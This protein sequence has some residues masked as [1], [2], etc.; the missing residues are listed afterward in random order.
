[1]TTYVKSIREDAERNA[2]QSF[3]EHI[4][5]PAG[6]DRWWFRRKNEWV[7]YG[8]GIIAAPRL[9]VM[10][11]DAGELMFEPSDRNALSWLRS[12]TNYDNY[13]VCYIASKVPLVMRKGIVEFQSELVER[14][15]EHVQEEINEGYGSKQLL[16]DLKDDGPWDNAHDFYEWLNNHDDRPDEF[17]DVEGLSYHF[18]HQCAGLA[19]FCRALRAAETAEEAA[20]LR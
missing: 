9:V 13:D 12:V 10:Y 8:F 11:G 7:P 2:R 16:E 19:A 17:P 6:D 15:A 4:L 1:M 20:R 3:G 5:V 18:L 14:Y